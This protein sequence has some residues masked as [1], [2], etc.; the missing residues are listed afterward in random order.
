MSTTVLHAPR[1]AAAG[2]VTYTPRLWAR[3]SPHPATAAR[4]RALDTGLNWTG[5]T[6]HDPG[7]RRPI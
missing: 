2:A 6:E 7:A 5:P 3:L 4:V 1:V